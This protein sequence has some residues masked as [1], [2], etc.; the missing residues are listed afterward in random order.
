[1]GQH[2]RTGGLAG[3]RNYEIDVQLALHLVGDIMTK[4]FNWCTKKDVTERNTDDM[5]S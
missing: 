2:T 4:L 3:V 5:I 1:M